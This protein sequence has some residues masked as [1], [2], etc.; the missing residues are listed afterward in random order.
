MLGRA[1]IQSLSK[2][3]Q[4]LTE[5]FLYSKNTEPVEVLH[6]MLLHQF[7]LVSKDQFLIERIQ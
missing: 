1:V 3:R 4:L 5:Y 2:D 6:S 7:I